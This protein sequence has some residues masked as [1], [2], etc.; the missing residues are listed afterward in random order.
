[1]H[2][3]LCLFGFCCNNLPDYDLKLKGRPLC[4][5]DMIHL[6]LEDIRDLSK[7]ACERNGNKAAIRSMSKFGLVWSLTALHCS[8]YNIARLKKA[9]K[10]YWFNEKHV[11]ENSNLPLVAHK[12]RRVQ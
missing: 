3:Y 2:P 8:Q 12:L 5:R 7:R 9:A 4:E 10:I 6:D 11:I 1:M